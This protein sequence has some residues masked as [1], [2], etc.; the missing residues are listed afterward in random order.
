MTAELEHVMD[1]ILPE[2]P[3]SHAFIDVILAIPKGSENEH[4][5]LVEKILKRN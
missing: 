3:C 2:F 4:I 5:A 1:A